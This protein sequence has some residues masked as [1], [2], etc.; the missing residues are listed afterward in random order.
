MTSTPVS[1]GG[2]W[3]EDFKHGQVFDDVPSTSMSKAT[4]ERT[5]LAAAAVEAGLA[6]SKGEASRLI[7]QGGV[8]LNGERVTDDRRLLT[9]ADTIGGRIAIFQRGQRERRIVRLEEA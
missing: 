4:F 1:V 5:T 7:K 3:F 8:Y 2:P 6:A 9:L